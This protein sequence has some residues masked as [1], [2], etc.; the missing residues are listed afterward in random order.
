M[1]KFDFHPASSLGSYKLKNKVNTHPKDRRPTFEQ[2]K[3]QQRLK[4][5]K[6]KR[7]KGR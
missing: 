6:K 7:R 1:S 3:E 5:L 4:K 2:V